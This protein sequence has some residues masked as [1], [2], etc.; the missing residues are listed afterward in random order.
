[1]M[2]VLSLTVVTGWGLGIDDMVRFL[3]LVM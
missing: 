1:L 3:L 2:A